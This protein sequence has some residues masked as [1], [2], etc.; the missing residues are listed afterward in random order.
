MAGPS[1]SPTPTLEATELP[2]GWFWTDEDLFLDG[3]TQ[4]TRAV[5]ESLG[6]RTAHDRIEIDNEG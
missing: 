2:E 1:P 3:Q 5:R 4:M 6:I